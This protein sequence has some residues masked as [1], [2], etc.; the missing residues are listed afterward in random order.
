MQQE[1]LKLLNDY[2]KN[3]AGTLVEWQKQI[4][5]IL[6][7][8]T[9]GDYVT[10]N[11][12]NVLLTDFANYYPTNNAEAAFALLGSILLAVALTPSRLVATNASGQL[13]SVA[14][15]QSWIEGVVNQTI[16]G[17]DGDGT[18]TISLPQ[19]IHKDADVEFDSLKL[20][21]LTAS[22]MI[23][24]DANKKLVS[25]ANLASWIAGTSYQ[26]SIADDGD[27]SITINFPSVVRLGN[28]AGGN[29]SE[30]EADG[31]LKCVGDATTFDDLLGD[32]T[33]LQVVGVGIVAD[34]TENALKFQ[35]S[36]NLS[37]YA[38]VNY[39][40]RHRWKSGS[41]AYPHIH[42]EQ[43]ENNVPNFLI[44]FRW[45][46]NRQSKTTAWTDYKCNTPVW[47]YVS[48]TFN[49]IV[50]GAAITP[51]AGYNISDIIQF[52]IFRDNAN[53]STVFSGVDPYTTDVLVTAIDIHIEED[54]LGSRTEYAK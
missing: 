46:R 20:D 17:D 30:F 39:Q 53:T 23:A 54:T 14:N 49:Q 24:S 29:Y 31:T 33:R 11:A 6:N 44:R 3:P 34:N 21:D 51:P 18:I 8:L 50:Y 19:D 7:N 1:F 26:I 37:D 32:I 41:N 27:G 45:Q 38:L 22:R 35:T 4:N 42:F 43:S 16:V 12:V 47:T 9:N 36:A 13:A 5:H 15:L 10:T 2:R 52:R 48:G 28:L 25:I 40:Q